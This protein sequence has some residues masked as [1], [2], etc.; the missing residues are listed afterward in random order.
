MLD[1]I[2]A[3]KDIVTV[4]T[5]NCLEMLDKALSQRPC[6]FDRVIKLTKPGFDQRLRIINYLCK[7]IP[8]SETLQQYIAGRTEGCSPAQVQEA[9]H[10]LVIEQADDGSALHVFSEQEVDRIVS[11][12]SGKAG[13]HLGFH[14]T[15]N[16]GIQA[17]VGGIMLDWNKH[18]L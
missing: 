9:I 7:Q 16:H 11:R 4:A 6:R 12:V 13:H 1:G 14:A 8:L 18:N 2:E 5:T 10:S 3:K 17:E 15:S